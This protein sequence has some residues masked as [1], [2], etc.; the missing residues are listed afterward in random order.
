MVEPKAEK[1]E[2]NSKTICADADTFFKGMAKKLDHT[3]SI[4]KYLHLSK[5]GCLNWFCQGRLHL[6]LCLN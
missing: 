5:C 4:L 6:K 3:V 1:I 2:M